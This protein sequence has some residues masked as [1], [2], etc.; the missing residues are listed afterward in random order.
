MLGYVAAWV[1]FLWLYAMMLIKYGAEP[2]SSG[3]LGVL[4]VC[5]ALSVIVVAVPPVLREIRQTKPEREKGRRKRPVLDLRGS[6]DSAGLRHDRFRASSLLDF[7]EYARSSSSEAQSFSNPM[8]GFNS[9]SSGSSATTGSSIIDETATPVIISLPGGDTVAGVTFQDVNGSVIITEISAWAPMRKE[10]S[11]DHLVLSLDGIAVTSNAQLQ[12]LL[13]ATNTKARIAARQ[14]VIRRASEQALLNVPHIRHS[15]RLAH[16]HA[17]LLGQGLRSR[18]LQQRRMPARTSISMPTRTKMKEVEQSMSGSVGDDSEVHDPEESRESLYGFGV[19]PFDDVNTEPEPVAAGAGAGARDASEDSTS[20]EHD[21]TDAGVTVTNTLVGS[22]VVL[23]FYLDQFYVQATIQRFESANMDLR[24]PPAGSRVEF[25]V[26]GE[27]VEARVMRFLDDDAGEK[28]DNKLAQLTIINW[29]ATD[30]TV[31][32][33]DHE[34]LLLDGEEIFYVVCGL[35]E[36]LEAVVLLEFSNWDA[37]AERAAVTVKTSRD[38]SYQGTLTLEGM[39]NDSAS[40][41]TRLEIPF[42]FTGDVV[43]TRGNATVA[44]P[45]AQQKQKTPPARRKKKVTVRR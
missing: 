33:L 9:S 45:A 13:W 19:S 28:T 17:R 3:F 4:L 16:P 30:Q 18:L 35:P 37:A 23:H 42:S 12:R 14:L 40:T 39:V 43:A 22:N 27:E 15:I 41:I 36:G 6:R 7:G 34:R 5:V 31:E 32:F 29:E 1:V 10:L 2:I 38:P 20:N 21:L 44:A 26:D 25:F 11:C 8:V 24:L